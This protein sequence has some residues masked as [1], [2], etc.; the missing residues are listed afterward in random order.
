MIDKKN[1]LRALLYRDSDVVL[2]LRSINDVDDRQYDRP[3]T[4]EKSMKLESIHMRRTLLTWID[5]T[6][7]TQP[8]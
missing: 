5:G 2:S 6:G 7:R 3:G 8:E 1:A 4:L